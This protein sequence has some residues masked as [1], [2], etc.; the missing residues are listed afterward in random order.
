MKAVRNAAEFA[1]AQLE[2][3]RLL[4]FDSRLHLPML[5]QKKPLDSTAADNALL[6]L[7]MMRFHDLEKNRFV[8]I[9]IIVFCKNSISD[10]N[11]AGTYLIDLCA[12]SSCIKETP[13]KAPHLLR[14]APF[15][16]RHT[17]FV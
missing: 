15:S 4:F 17:P 10:A 5:V 13:E 2:F 11:T 14:A 3:C 12:C 6:R 7:S 1:L 16:S 9:P 8:G